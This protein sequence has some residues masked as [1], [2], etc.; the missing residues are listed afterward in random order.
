MRLVLAS[1]SAMGAFAAHPM[2]LRPIEPKILEFSQVER[3]S[4]GDLSILV[5][6]TGGDSAFDLPFRWRLQLPGYA[7]MDQVKKFMNDNIRALFVNM[8]YYPTGD[9]KERAENFKPHLSY[10][11]GIDCGNSVGVVYASASKSH[12]PLTCAKFAI[13][14]DA[15]MA[16]LTPPENSVRP[17]NRKVSKGLKFA[18]PLVV[19]S[20]EAGAGSAFKSWEMP[21]S[22]D[23]AAVQKVF[24]H[25][26]QLLLH[27]ENY[28][29]K[30]G[31][32]GMA[33]KILTYAPIQAGMIDCG[34]YVGILD[35][36]L[37]VLKAEPKRVCAHF[38]ILKEEAT[39][40]AGPRLEMTEPVEEPGS[41]L[42]S[43]KPG[44]EGTRAS[45]LLSWLVPVPPL[46]GMDL[47]KAYVPTEIGS[48]INFDLFLDYE[49]VK[50]EAENFNPTVDRSTDVVI[51]C[52]DAAGRVTVARLDPGTESAICGFFSLIAHSAAHEIVSAQGKDISPHSPIDFCDY[53]VSKADRLLKVR[54]DGERSFEMSIAGLP[55]DG[56]A[57]DSKLVQDLISRLGEISP[58]DLQ[59]VSE[60]SMEKVEATVMHSPIQG[61]VH[62][63]CDEKKP[64][65]SNGKLPFGA[66]FSRLVPEDLKEHLPA[67][68]EKRACAIMYNLHASLVR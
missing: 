31:V 36:D 57:C 48:L 62:V 59:A 12:R 56:S 30:D 38:Q 22:G 45:I 41:L 34:P 33:N 37:S 32:A 58:E 7:D 53:V 52:G 27:F 66:S 46:I 60:E 23:A 49:D 65:W 10:D 67:D 54:F 16:Q 28:L 42:V 24:A 13:Q 35:V 1:V 18:S 2:D 47:V 6:G 3:T 14:R 8:N 15:L 68:W 51:E 39:K 55:E 19:I 26:S 21:L 4:D 11:N 29:E 44:S 43:L 17:E 63:A 9:I 40:T 20:A 64:D 61:L 50:K 5:V 25:Q